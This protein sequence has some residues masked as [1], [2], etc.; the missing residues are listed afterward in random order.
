MNALLRLFS[1]QD[2]ARQTEL[3][4]KI[5]DQSANEKYQLR[6]KIAVPLLKELKIWLE[7]KVEKTA[8]KPAK[9][10]LHKN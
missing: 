6:Q 2:S 3:E 8:K 10:C 4:S 9:S 1:Q 5:K 7:K